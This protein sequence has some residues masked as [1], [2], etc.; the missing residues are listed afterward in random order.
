M[1]KD[2]TFYFSHDY[3]TRNDIKVKR[4][5]S[6]HGYLGYGIF[7]GIIEDLYNNANAL[8]LDYDCLAFDYRCSVEVI[9]S[10]INDFE[11]FSILDNL[12]YSDSVGR[13]LAERE[14]KSSKARLSAYNRW[15]TSNED[16]NALQT[17]CESNAIK[18]SKGKESKG[19][20][21]KDDVILL[22][23]ESKDKP[24]KKAEFIPPSE[25]EVIDYFLENGY[26][27]ETAKK[28]FQYYAV[29]N[30]ID[31][32]GKKIKSWKQKM[33]SVWFKDENRTSPQS[34]LAPKLIF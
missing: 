1:A 5:V 7:W 21:S 30:W 32:N 16:A 23:K 13:R 9:K 26:N 8:P 18:E 20:E 27:L 15:R 33:I 24:P 2:N 34:N 31:S 3:N 12:F 25:K 14:S 6:K 22:K 17:Q 11:L 28:A 10:I 4:L 19:N 29:A